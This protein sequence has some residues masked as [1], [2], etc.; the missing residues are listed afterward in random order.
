MKCKINT[1]KLKQMCSICGNGYIP[2]SKDRGIIVENERLEQLQRFLNKT[3]YNDNT[4]F[5]VFIEMKEGIRF[6]K[7]IQNINLLPKP[8]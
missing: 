7:G 5:Y 2:L 4:E 1:K 3:E 6:Y 8:F